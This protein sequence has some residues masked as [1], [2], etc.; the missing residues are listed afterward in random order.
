MRFITQFA[1]RSIS[2]HLSVAFVIL[3]VITAIAIGA[4]AYWIISTELDQQ[5]WARIDDA[6]HVVEVSM[7][8][9]RARLDNVALLAAQRP[10]LKPIIQ[11]GDMAAL[12]DYL[13]TFQ[14]DLL[15]D[16]MAVYDL[17]GNLLAQKGTIAFEPIMSSPTPDSSS[18]LWH[19]A[20]GLA[21]V[22]GRPVY[23]T[24]S[25]DL[26]GHILVGIRLDDRFVRRMAVETGFDQSLLLDGVRV[27]TS[28][29]NAP[30]RASDWSKGEQA[31]AAKAALKTE[32]TL[33]D[34]RYYSAL[35]PLQFSQ[36]PPR[37][38]LEV[39]MPIDNL[40]AAQRRALLTLGLSALVVSV[41]GSLLGSFYA[42]RLSSPI[43]QL[44]LAARQIA[45]DELPVK[46]PLAAKVTEVAALAQV[47]SDSRT[48][49]RRTLEELSRAKIWT[50]TVI[51]SMAEGVITF[52][53]ARRITF[54]SRGAEQIT[55]WTSDE[56]REQ[57][58][59]TVLNL[60]GHDAAQ[61]I[62]APG[63]KREI[64]IVTRDRQ[65]KTLE[66]T[67]AELIPPEGDTVQSVLVLRDITDQETGRRL[68]S[69]FLGNITH[70]FRTPISGLKASIELLLEEVDYLSLDEIRELL[71]SI[72]LSVSGLQALVDNLL[73][74]VSIEAGQFSIHRRAV[75]LNQ[76]IAN[77]IRMVQPLLDRRSQRLSLTEPLQLSSVQAD[78][79]RLTQVMINLLANASKYSPPQAVI[80][81]DLEETGD[82]VRVCVADRGKGIPA[83][84]RANLFSRFVRLT[85]D[86][87]EQHGIGLGLSVVKAIIEGHGGQVGVDERA[88]GGSVFWFTL[89]L[90]STTVT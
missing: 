38:V 39:V 34:Q 56:A 9:E 80:D 13:Q 2:T 69:Y 60:P 71:N 76:V 57:P 72:H 41:I 63:G 70:E 90:D 27:A 61:F 37:V 62:P 6:Q 50:E 53:A 59:D 67:S 3:V 33:G 18:T 1:R 68:H 58:I 52:D 35:I 22:T 78:A 19:D 74:S 30:P 86:T 5:A 87:A 81:V 32:Q 36:E 25:E 28:L 16:A 45:Q 24:L 21:L 20:A 29:E 26:L 73:E 31:L 15:L 89:P 66:V 42:T 51:Q 49:I 54:F 77:A 79:T 17:S 8:A 11:R 12:S 83:E 64:Q 85:D 47:L 88:G 84:A 46:M 43:R 82:M 55:G 65:R 4:P 23:D 48:T 40:I 14:A 10:S 75:N 44:T 7:E